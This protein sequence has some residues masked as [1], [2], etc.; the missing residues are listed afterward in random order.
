M[1]HR[2]VI[3]GGGTGGITVAA[4]LARKIE[5]RD[6]VVLDAADDHYYQPAWTLVGGGLYNAKDTVRKL[7]TLIPKGALLR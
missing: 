2:V 1:H 7:A 6:I 4:Q 5:P 3:A